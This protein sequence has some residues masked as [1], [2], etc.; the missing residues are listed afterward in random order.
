MRS[1]EQRLFFLYFIYD[2][3]LITGAF[4][5]AWLYKFG[6]WEQAPHLVLL[7]VMWFSWAIVAGMFSRHSLYFR[8]SIGQRTKALIFDTVTF[9]SIVSMVI[10]IVNIE[11]YS[12]IMIFGTILTFLFFKFITY[13][14]LYRYLAIRRAKGRHVSRVLVLGA[15]SMAEKMWQFTENHIDL[16]FKVVG[17]LSDRKPKPAIEKMY[18]GGL[19]KFED[20]VVKEDVKEVIITLT[21]DDKPKLQKLIDIADFHGLR[22][23]WVPDYF[24]V[25]NREFEV[26]HMGKIPV[27]NIREIPLDH[28]PWQ[29]AKRTFDIVFSIAV[30]IL[31]SPLFLVLSLIIKLS[32]GGPVLYTPERVG[33]DGK[34]FKCFKF[35]SMVVDNSS[36]HATKSTTANDP[37]ITKI[38]AIMRKTSLD[39]MP[40]F[41]NV[42]LGDMSVVGPRPHRVF[43]DKQIQQS[44]HGYMVRHYIR[45]G[46]TGWAQVNGWRGPAETQQQKSERTRHDLWY[47]GNWSFWLDLR[48]IFL[49]VFGKKTHRD[50]F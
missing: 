16:G 44:V 1:R 49:T 50:V 26:G 20:T 43:L 39:E 33:K 40:Q 21:S 41:M 47:M 48:I 36:D 27:V 2:L 10:L 32:D 11:I 45:P 6:G 14:Y 4:A 9:T 7:P 18:L 17:F 19:E 5:L 35:R 24:R 28:L 15:G 23:R 31:L 3:F 30:L 38:G 46:I 8:D 37:R 25:L 42:L 13:H 22:I 12:R 34:P 29:M